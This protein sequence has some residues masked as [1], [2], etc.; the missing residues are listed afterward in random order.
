[1][2]TVTTDDLI[3]SEYLLTTRADGGPLEVTLKRMLQRDGSVK[4]R[5]ARGGWCLARDGGWEHEPLPSSRTD[6]FFANCRYAS[7]AEALVVWEAYLAREA[8]VEARV[9]CVVRP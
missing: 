2:P 7:T 6:E 9:G 8:A 1:M 3:V 4:W 5:I